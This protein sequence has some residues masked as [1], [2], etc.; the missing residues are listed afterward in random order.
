[1]KSVDELV[2]AWTPEERERF[3]ELIDECREREQFLI[4]TSRLSQENL[5]KLNQL[6]TSLR[7]KSS[8]LK[9]ALDGFADSLFGLYLRFYH[10]KLPSC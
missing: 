1:M 6:E 7:L 5:L 4:E 3:K 8:E 10:Q 9:K 2:S